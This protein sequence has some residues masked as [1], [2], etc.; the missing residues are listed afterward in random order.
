MGLG[1]RKQ[2]SI[3]PRLKYDGRAGKFSLVNRIHENG[4]W[5]N[6]QVDIAQSDFRAVFDLDNLEVGWIHYPE[7]SAPDI[8][9]V[10]AGQDVGDAPSDKHKE[11]IRLLVLMDDYLDGSVRELMSTA[12]GLWNGLDTLHDAYM[13][14]HDKN[15][16]KLPV[17][18][19]S[20]TVDTGSAANPSHEPVFAITEWVPRPDK[21]P[22]EGIPVSQS[23]KKKPAPATASVSTKRADIDDEIPF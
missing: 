1:K 13:V 11:G 18:V 15:P 2:T 10:K 12:G 19:L 22:P 14:D 8:K 5:F 9:L 20:G 4:E 16:G 17:V 21:L 23:A 6:D 7:G 3:T